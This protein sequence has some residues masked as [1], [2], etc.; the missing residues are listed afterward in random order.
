MK[1][2]LFT[3]WGVAALLSCSIGIVILTDKLGKRVTFHKGIVTGKEAYQGAAIVAFRLK[4]EHLPNP[5]RFTVLTDDNKRVTVMGSGIG[6]EENDSIYFT[7]EE[8]LRG[9]VT[10]ILA[11]WRA[12][13]TSFFED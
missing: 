2:Q 12:I 13:S 7:R 4:V 5:T 6:I 11:D 1:Q 9:F 3:S 8:N 10:N